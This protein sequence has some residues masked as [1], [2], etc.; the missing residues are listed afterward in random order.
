MKFRKNK[1]KSSKNPPKLYEKQSKTSPEI[2]KKM[3]PKILKKSQKSY[4]KKSPNLKNLIK[5]RDSRRSVFLDF[6]LRVKE[7][8]NSDCR[9]GFLVKNCI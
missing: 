6:L 3:A 8:V 7:F 4:L 2:P 1:T 9:F 5:N